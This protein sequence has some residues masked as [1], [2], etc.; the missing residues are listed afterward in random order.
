MYITQELMQLSSTRHGCILWLIKSQKIKCN[1]NFNHSEFS[2]YGMELFILKSM[3]G[4]LIMGNEDV[5]IATIIGEWVWSYL[6]SNLNSISMTTYGKII[7][8]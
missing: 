5:W 3:L 8:A 2:I 1:P 7:S 6:D 4:C